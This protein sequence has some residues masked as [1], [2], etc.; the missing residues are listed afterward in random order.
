MPNCC[1]VCGR[2]KAI[3]PSISLYHIPKQSDLQKYWLDGLN[4]SE[5]KVTGDSRVCSRHF[6]DR[7]PKN[8]P[9]IHIGEKF[10]DRPAGKTA[11]GK[12]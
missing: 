9:S 1:T 5:D 10:S 6:H 7:N 3:D 2:S 12:R 8:V 11:R 4:L